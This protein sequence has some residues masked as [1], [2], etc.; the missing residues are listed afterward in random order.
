MDASTHHNESVSDGSDFNR[1][2]SIWLDE[3]DDIFSDFDPRPY[4]E[5]ALSD[6]FIGELKKVC[7][8]DELAVAEIKLL[9]PE[10]M[11]KPEYEATI[12][13]RLHAHFRK[14]Y[15]ILT[16]RVRVMRAKA[17]A[18]SMAGIVL[19]FSA[20]MI[21]TQQSSNV[22]MRVMLVLFEPAGWFFIW[23]GMDNLF[24]S[25]R[26]TQ[27]DME[28]YTKLSKSKVVFGSF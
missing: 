1:Q 18:M 25:S 2:V 8:E 14:V 17:L 19:L 7:R 27:L 10:K 26:Q 28:F 3:Y 23:T 5:R 22:G 9:L 15:A 21:T 16:K 24:F 12:V 6:D 4:S 11:R 20:S 13:K